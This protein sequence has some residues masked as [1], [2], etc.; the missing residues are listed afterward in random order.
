MRSRENVAAARQSMAASRRSLV[1]GVF[2]VGSL[3]IASVQAS[4]ASLG[5]NV[6]G[7]LAAAH[8]LSPKLR[9]AALKTAA[10]SAKAAGA[11][12]L[13]DPNI[14]DSYQYYKDPGVYSAHTV[15][16][17]QMVPLW[18]KL[19]LRREAAFADVDAARGRE[20]AAR[21]ALDE[22]IKVAY[23]QYYV[24]NRE[25]AV[26]N[27]VAALARQMGAAATARY[28][29]GGGDQ[30]GAIQAHGEETSAKLEAIGL[31]GALRADR[32]ML[33]TLVARRADAPLAAPRLLPRM[34]RTLPRLNALLARAR[35][36]NPTL[37]AGVSAIDA[38]RTRKTLADKAW[39][40]DLTLGAGPIIQTNNQPVGF[41][42]TV[43]LNIPLPWGREASAQHEAEAK[44]AAMRQQYDGD[45]FDIEGALGKA[46][47][48][49][50]AARQEERVLRGQ[51][52]PQSHAAFQSVLAT[53]SQGK[54]ELTAP[55]AAERQ[56]R[57]VEVTLLKTQLKE[58]VEMAALE[59]LIGG[60]L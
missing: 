45:V 39:L 5:A 22:Q 16:V 42:A 27:E 55:I 9:A 51:T 43:G 58:Q 38:A 59:R 11:D 8:R 48:T 17:T 19:A 6:Q 23:A 40:P 37:S 44:L 35:A 4:A 56:I 53:Y 18:G 7:L 54:S 10:A 32:D 14:T 31:E 25:I 26:N 50:R 20:R 1:L 60:E 52:L 49:L 46:L 28:G 34:P 15:M 47:A 12:A 2:F 21:D 33:N 3:A 36:A 30:A 57:A 13:D 29:Q 24:T 41:A